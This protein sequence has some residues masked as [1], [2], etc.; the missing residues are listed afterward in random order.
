MKLKTFFLGVLV[1][2]GA[3]AVVCWQLSSHLHFD[4][5]K[6]RSL[7]ISGI[8]A[9]LNIVAAFFTVKYTIN[10][11]EN[12]F[13][14]TFFGGMGVR[15]LILLGLII[16]II[17]FVDVNQFTFIFSLLILYVLYQIWEIWLINSY[18]RKE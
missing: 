6:I 10:K 2:I 18:L 14:K 15:V 8:I 16:S 12:L 3:Y 5:S 11:A 13:F 7:W 9:T 17:K 4:A 1:I